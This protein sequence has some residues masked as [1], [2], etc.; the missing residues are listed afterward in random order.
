VALKVFAAGTCS[1]EEWTAR[2]EAG[3]NLWAALAH[4]HIVAVQ[5]A[6]WWEGAP[7][8]VTDYV[9]TGSL[10]AKLSGQ[11]YPLL[12]ALRLVEQLA[13][14]VMYLHRQGV[15]HANLKPT[16]VLLAA[17][18]IPQVGDFRATGGLF[19]GPLPLHEP[20]VSGLGY[21]APEFVENP[22]AQLHPPTDIYSLGVILYELLTGLPP[23]SGSTA[24]ETLEQ[25]RS[26]DAEP[27]SHFNSEITPQLD[28]CC[29]RCL[30]KN[31]WGRY[32]RAY[33]LIR[34]LRYFQENPDGTNSSS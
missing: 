34:R 9:P 1:Q 10:A 5:R 28:A 32:H 31:P 7:F 11:P 22:S 15:V 27:P 24:R 6:G 23:F 20:Q 33:D 2:F 3:A 13:E 26:Q 4:P 16:N 25:V 17:D 18:G 19:Q 12:A 8:V 29:L 30:R 14:I 21:L